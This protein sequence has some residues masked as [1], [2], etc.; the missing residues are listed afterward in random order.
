MPEILSDK[1]KQTREKRRGGRP[2]VPYDET[3][4][5]CS[6]CHEWKEHSEFYSRNDN[7]GRPVVSRCKLCYRTLNGHR[8]RSDRPRA[9]LYSGGTKPSQQRAVGRLCSQGKKCVTAA[10]TGEVGRLSRYNTSTLCNLCE[11]RKTDRSIKKAQDD[12]ERIEAKLRKAEDSQE[13]NFDFVE[14]NGLLVRLEK[15]QQ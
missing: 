11:K 2:G 4:A 15:S 1:I 8:V 14:V 10:Q 3:H 6:G 9:G 7:R 5:E 12:R 13:E